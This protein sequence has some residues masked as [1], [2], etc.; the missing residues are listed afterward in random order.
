MVKRSIDLIASQGVVSLERL[1]GNIIPDA[2]EVEFKMPFGF[3][4]LFKGEVKINVTCHQS[5]NKIRLHSKGLRTIVA[6]VT[7]I[8]PPTKE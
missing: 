8:Q 7:Q 4:K 5:T 2:Y 3:D 6:N 1:S